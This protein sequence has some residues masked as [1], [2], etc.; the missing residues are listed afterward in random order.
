M[1]VAFSSAG[2]ASIPVSSLPKISEEAAIWLERER[3]LSPETLALVPVASGTTYFPELKGRSP[4]IFFGYA[5]GWKA[6]AIPHKAFVAAKGWK[7]SFWNLK[8][9]LDALNADNHGFDLLLTEGEIDCISLIECGFPAYQCLSVPNG[10]SGAESDRGIPYVDEAL[11]A[12]L[13]KAKKVIWCG[14]SDEVGLALRAQMAQ[15]FG[16]AKFYYVDWPDGIKDANDLLKAQGPDALRNHILAESRPWPT[17]GIYKLSELPEPPKLTLWEPSIE[18][19]QGKVFLAP[20][21][22]SLFIGQPGHGKSTFAGQLWFEIIQKYG[23]VGCFAS[24]ETRPK[25]HMRRQIRSLFNRAAEYML[26]QQEITAADQFIDDHYLFVNHP[27]QRP[28]LDWFLDMAEIAVVRH[29]ARILQIDPWNRLEAS[30]AKDETETEHIGRCLRALSVFAHDMN[31]HVQ[32]I[33]HPAKMESQR[34]GR[35]PE[36][37]DA[38]G[39]KHWENMIDQGFVIHRP[40][41]FDEYGTRLTKAMFIVRKCRFE[42]LG[43][44]M[45]ANIDYDLVTKTYISD[46]TGAR[47]SIDS[48]E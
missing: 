46:P 4:A 16:I 17:T 44:P 8:Q 33:C 39:S 20:Q 26:T 19:L 3:S 23:L 1:T 45:A 48:I 31:C 13:N 5:N 34:R 9:V 43:Y 7:P 24:F 36:L 2:T 15:Q 12:G 28:T 40:R 35:A 42:E 29:G 30:R 25:P 11:A 22:V 41:L 21:T 38:A 37:E 32:I 18:C 14:D 6:R 47:E 10:A 27:E